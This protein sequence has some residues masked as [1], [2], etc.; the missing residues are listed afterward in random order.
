MTRNEVFL[1]PVLDRLQGMLKCFHDFSGVA[2]GDCLFSHMFLS[3]PWL[4]HVKSIQI[5]FMVECVFIVS[6]FK[7]QRRNRSRPVG[8][9]ANDA[10]PGDPPGCER[11]RRWGRLPDDR[12]WSCGESVP[13]ETADKS[14][15]LSTKRFQKTVW[16]EVFL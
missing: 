12:D 6:S 3:F 14:S 16:G 10:N 8:R 11:A 4:N 5:P 2:Y 9:F 7:G 1:G 15:V 13:P